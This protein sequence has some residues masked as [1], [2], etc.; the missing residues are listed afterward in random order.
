[1]KI[2]LD[3]LGMNID[4]KGYQ[5]FYKYTYFPYIEILIFPKI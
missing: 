1:M 5:S 2:N 3:V 4:V